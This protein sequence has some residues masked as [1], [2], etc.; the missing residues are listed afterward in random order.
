MWNR[1]P[2]NV[3][4]PPYAG[5]IP[6]ISDHRYVTQVLK[7]GTHTDVG[8]QFPWDYFTERINFYA[9]VKAPVEPSEPTGPQPKVH[10]RD[11][12]DRELLEEIWTQLRGPGGKGWPQLGQNSRGQNLSLVDGVAKLLGD[13]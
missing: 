4:A 12:T 5:R 8:D 3:V 6:G 1:I 9:N 13:K 10:P 2:F 7:D 11:F